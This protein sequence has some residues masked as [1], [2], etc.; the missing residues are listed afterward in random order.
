MWINLSLVMVWVLA[1]YLSRK[2]YGDVFTPLCVYTSIWCICLLLFH[3]RLIDYN[4]LGRKTVLLISGSMLGFG[5]G[6]FLAGTVNQR[7]KRSSP[8]AFQLE[9]FEA[10]LKVLA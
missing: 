4:E 9:K 5:S 3:L 10:G 1:V 7:R 2:R 6:C 8:R